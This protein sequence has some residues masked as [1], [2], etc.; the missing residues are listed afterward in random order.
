MATRKGKSR[1]KTVAQ[2]G[3]DGYLKLR[4]VL[5]VDFVSNGT[6]RETL[7]AN[8]KRICDRAADEGLIS[9]QTEAEV[10]SW[11]CRVE[12]RE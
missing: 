2:R 3:D 8:L 4:L 6:P 9:A 1:A 7:E 12:G 10:D 5:D 11:H